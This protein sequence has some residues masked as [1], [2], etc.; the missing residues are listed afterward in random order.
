LGANFLDR[1]SAALLHPKPRDSKSL[2][3][4]DHPGMAI[5]PACGN[6]EITSRI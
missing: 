6:D 3:P 5:E 1:H 2:L 4:S